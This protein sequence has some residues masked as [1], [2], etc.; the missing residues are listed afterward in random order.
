M[1]TTKLEKLNVPPART[2]YEEES[3]RSPV[4]PKPPLPPK[5]VKKITS[6]KGES[7]DEAVE[8]TLKYPIGDM[9]NFLESARAQE[10]RKQRELM[11]PKKPTPKKVA[12]KAEVESESD[13]ES[14]AEPD[15][16][17]EQES[18]DS[19]DESDNE[20]AEDD[21]HI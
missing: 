19:E 18:A 11:K 16:E 4:T 14:D 20:S 15:V 1:K 21:L 9:R 6:K 2:N 5:A 8:S 10:E 3:P 7:K 13:E 12:K 17:F